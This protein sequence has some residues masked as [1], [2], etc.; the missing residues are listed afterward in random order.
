MNKHIDI[1]N[2]S[3]NEALQLKKM[4]AAKNKQKFDTDSK[5]RLKNIAATKLKTTFIGAL[6]KFEEHFG[7]LWGFGSN[8]PLT[9]IQKQYFELWEL[10]RTDILNNG[11]NQRR[12]LLNEIEQQTISWNRHHI[13]LP[14]KSKTQE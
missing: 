11:N 7:H 1:S 12:A 2:Y 5:Q 10:C 9:E 14:V 13:S 3:N 4:I 8:E 6:S